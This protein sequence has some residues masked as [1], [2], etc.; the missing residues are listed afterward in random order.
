MNRHAPHVLIVAEDDANR[1]MAVGFEGHPAVKYQWLKVQKAGR[2]WQNVLKT[3]QIELVPYLQKYLLAHVILLIDY[4]NVY[5][6]RRAQFDAA[7]PI[8]LKDRVF[9][10]GA[11]SSP[12]YL[13]NALGMKFREIG[14]AL[15]GDCAD[16]TMN[17][18]HHPQL[19]HNEPDRLRLLTKVRGI[20][21]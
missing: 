4:D 5:A 9:V 17:L 6:A 8:A 13:H 12:E 16:G 19:I 14:N 7:T 11:E 10:L 20:L 2:G 15:A 3:F 18:W 21:F 1:Q